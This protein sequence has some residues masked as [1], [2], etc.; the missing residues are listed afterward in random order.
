MID[1]T[2]SYS[3]KTVEST[4]IQTSIAG[5]QKVRYEGTI[6]LFTTLGNPRHKA[7]AIEPEQAIRGPD[8]DIAVCSLRD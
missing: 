1:V 2:V 4:Y 3:S 7:D 6:K 5:S 8:P